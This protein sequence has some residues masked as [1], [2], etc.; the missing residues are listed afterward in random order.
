MITLSSGCSQYDSLLRL[1]D[2]PWFADGYVKGEGQ[3]VNTNSKYRLSLISEVKE[4]LSLDKSMMS[5]WISAKPPINDNKE[6]QRKTGRK[7]RLSLVNRIVYPIHPK[8][9]LV[10]AT[11]LNI[12]KE[13]E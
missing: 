10:R 11:T 4:V 5:Q 2:Q 9:E 8:F 6:V 12:S 7:Y 13:L 1:R 3:G